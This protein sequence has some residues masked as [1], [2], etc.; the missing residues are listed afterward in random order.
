MIAQVGDYLAASKLGLDAELV[1]QL[2]DLDGVVAAE[3]KGLSVVDRA[4]TWAHRTYR[5]K[6]SP[7]WTRIVLPPTQLP[8]A[9][10]TLP[11]CSDSIVLS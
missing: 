7:V 11:S 1:E 2:E 3:K 9:S 6:M 5:S 8:W 4:G 10:V